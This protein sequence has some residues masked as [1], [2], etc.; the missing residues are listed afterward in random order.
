MSAKAG[1]IAPILFTLLIAIESLLRP[2]YSQISNYVSG[3]G[4]G[5]YAIIQNPN[6]ILI[7]FLSLV[8][9]F[10]FGSIMT[11]THWRRPGIVVGITSIF[12][13]GTILAGMSLPYLAYFVHIPATFTAFFAVIA[14]QLLTW[15]SLKT[16]NSK[17]WGGY[18]KY[19]LICGLLSLV[20]LFVFIN[21]MSSPY[22]GATERALIAP[23]LIWLAITGMK[24]ETQAKTEQTRPRTRAN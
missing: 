8:F 12:G 23:S 2:G 21:T 9:A 17:T 18:R 19:S 10:G 4:V 7:G 15:A 16:S 6:F 3:L 5:P 14:A 13:L 20:L 24:V 22:L 11:A 1:I